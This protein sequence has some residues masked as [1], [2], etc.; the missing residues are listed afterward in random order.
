MCKD[1]RG[2]QENL[3]KPGYCVNSP[4]QGVQEGVGR[5]LERWASPIL[6]ITDLWICPRLLTREF[7]FSCTSD[8]CTSDF[9]FTF[10]KTIIHIVGQN[11]SMPV[12]SKYGP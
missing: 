11:C 8:F 10:K 9:C 1:I 4:A 2:G 3:A 7:L 5:M 6:K 12:F